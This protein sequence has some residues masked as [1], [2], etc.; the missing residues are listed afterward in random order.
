MLEGK[1]LVK[2]RALSLAFS[3]RLSCLIRPLAFSVSLELALEEKVLER[4]MVRPGAL[5]L[6]CSCR[7]FYPTHL[8]VL[9]VSP[10]LALEKGLETE[11]AR[12]CALFLSCSY[13]QF[14]PIHPLL[15]SAPLEP[16]AL[17]RRALATLKRW[18]CVFDEVLAQTRIRSLMLW[19]R[20]PLKAIL[21]GQDFSLWAFAWVV[22]LRLCH[23]GI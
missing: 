13:H 9:S 19:L 14:Y 11:M 10:E 22:M 23:V 4:E 1:G 16:L 5:V 3:C 6:S 18:E 15:L 12:A 8:L 2:A 7:Q 21:T 17:V 20:L